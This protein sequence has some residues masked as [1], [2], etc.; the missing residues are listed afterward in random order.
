M[1]T[2]FFPIQ[3]DNFPPWQQGRIQEFSIGGGDHFLR[4]K[5]VAPGH[6]HTGALFLQT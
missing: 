6:P 1:A 4:R 5:T 2:S 3:K